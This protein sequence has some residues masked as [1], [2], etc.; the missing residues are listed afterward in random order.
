[1]QSLEVKYGM[2]VSLY[3]LLANDLFDEVGPAPILMTW[4]ECKG[5]G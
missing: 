5:L 1:M 2:L 3:A 4:F